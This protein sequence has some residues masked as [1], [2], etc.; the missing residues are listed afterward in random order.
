MHRLP[1]ARSLALALALAA[2]APGLAP[3]DLPAGKLALPEGTEPSSR[4]LFGFDLGAGVDYLPSTEVADDWFGNDDYDSD[5]ATV[6]GVGADL[7]F[8]V[9]VVLG[10]IRERNGN[11]DTFL[12]G[13]Q[14]S[15]SLNWRVDGDRPDLTQRHHLVLGLSLNR[16]ATV[17]LGGGFVAYHD[18]HGRAA[19]GGGVT[20][21]ARFNLGRRGAYFSMP[22][23]IDIF[24]GAADYGE[25]TVVTMRVA[26]RFGWWGLY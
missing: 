6:V 3:A 4:G 15:L 18:L 1:L 9:G 25:T 20:V 11:L 16:R 14:P 7:S 21:E 13:Y 10:E 23:L 5:E 8:F 19:A 24:P 17:L 2:L 26:L 22:G 12:L